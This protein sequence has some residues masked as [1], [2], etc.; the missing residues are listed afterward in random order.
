M[1]ESHKK[2]R[3]WMWC[4]LGGSPCPWYPWGPYS[5]TCLSI[6][7]SQSVTWKNFPP[8]FPNFSAV[9]CLTTRVW[10]REFCPR[11]Q[12]GC[13]RNVFMILTILI[14][15][16]EWNCCVCLCWDYSTC[17]RRW[18]DGC[19]RRTRSNRD[20]WYRR[21]Y[22]RTCRWGCGSRCWFDCTCKDNCVCM[23]R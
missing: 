5:T 3:K 13:C 23:L 20:C 14:A 1:R 15:R 18:A 8:N 16:N 7:G 21:R 22:S 2:R 11:I 12:R 9:C 4:Y 19:I 6:A 17:N 10:E